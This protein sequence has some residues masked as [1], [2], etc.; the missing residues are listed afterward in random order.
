[1]S[2]SMNLHGI[3]SIALSR[4]TFDA[5]TSWTAI[6]IIDRDGSKVNVTCFDPDV[7]HPAAITT[8]DSVITAALLAACRDSLGPTQDAVSLAEK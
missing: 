7:A 6:L 5:H 2:I 4:K 1:M 3:Q 8:P